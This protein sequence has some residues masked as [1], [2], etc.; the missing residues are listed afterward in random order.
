[1]IVVVLGAALLLG[2][3]RAFERGSAEAASRLQAEEARG[4][5]RELRAEL[6]LCME[7]LEALETRFAARQQAAEDLRSRIDYLE[8]LHPDGVPADSYAAY[9]ETVD[10]F[11]AEVSGWD[12]ESG[13]LQDKARRCRGLVEAHNE[14]A[15]ELFRLLVEAGMW[16]EGWERPGAEAAPE[17]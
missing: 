16:E 6:D 11:N 13:Q 5:V 1:M 7:R 8:G 14:R 4:E 3:A 15:D 10:E 17:R 12:E 2:I 9:L